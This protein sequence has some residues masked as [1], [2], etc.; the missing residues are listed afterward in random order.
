MDS[1]HDLPIRQT[2]RQM[3]AGVSPFLH[4][5][6]LLPNSLTFGS[7]R[8]KPR[9]EQANLDT[10][11]AICLHSADAAL[12][13]ANTLPGPAALRQLNCVTDSMAVHR[14]PIG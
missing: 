3:I 8:E 13:S 14:K 5:P 12:R 4:D 1:A 2:H 6:G 10:N 7:L 11:V 9:I